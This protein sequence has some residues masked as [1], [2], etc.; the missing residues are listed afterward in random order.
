MDTVESPFS[1]TLRHIDDLM[2]EARYLRERITA[3]LRRLEA[4]LFPERRRRYERHEPERRN[5]VVLGDSPEFRDIDQ[6]ALSRYSA[7][8]TPDAE[9]RS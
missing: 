7:G 9:I 6:L 1:E 8:P 5:Q 4:P 2:A 3:A